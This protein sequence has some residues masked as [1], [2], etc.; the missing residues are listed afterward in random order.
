LLAAILGLEKCDKVPTWE[1]DYLESVH[2]V[3]Y[4]MD[5]LYLASCG[6][7]GGCREQIPDARQAAGNKIA[8]PKLKF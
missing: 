6:K 1:L 5:R 2:K 7:P 4:F 8:V 3:G